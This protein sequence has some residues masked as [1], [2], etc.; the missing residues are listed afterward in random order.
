MVEPFAIALHAVRRSPPGLNYAVVVLGAGMIGLALVQALSHTGCG[1]L[2]VLD[3]ANDRLAMA[4]K[5]GAT[6]TINSGKED[7]VQAIQSLTH[8]RGVDVSFEAVGVTPTVELALRCLRKGGAATL[9]GN[10]APKI[11]FPL[12]VAVTRELTIHGSCASRGEYPACLE[13]LARGDLKAEPLISAVAPLAEGADW[14]GRLY[15]KEPGLLK[16]VLKP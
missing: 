9:V 10:V 12:Q 11:D 3:V 15:R 7:G 4:A 8:G 2:I 5:L 16:V 13:M 1:K 6:H 14:F